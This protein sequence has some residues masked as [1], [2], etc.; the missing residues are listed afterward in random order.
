VNAERPQRTGRTRTD[1]GST[2]IGDAKERLA[3]DYLRRH[4]LHPV[5]RN[6]RCR[7]GEIDL[8]MRDGETLVFVEVRYR[9]S[10]RYGTP[11]ETV[12]PRKQRRLAA[13][14]SHYLQRHPNMLP[15]RFDVVAV[16]AEDRIDWIKNAFLVEI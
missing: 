9:R 16:G 10:D 7:H 11:A 6:H 5:A 3:E 14:A 12:N 4:K 13:A 1:Q 2:G 8:V 15:C